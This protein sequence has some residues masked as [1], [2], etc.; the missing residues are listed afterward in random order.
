M[1]E[2]VNKILRKD[3]KPCPFCGNPP[4]L[5]IIPKEENP[6]WYKGGEFWRIECSNEWCIPRPSIRFGDL[7]VICYW[8]ER[9][10]RNRLTYADDYKKSIYEDKEMFNETSNTI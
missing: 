4:Y 9:R 2:K 6:E 10:R 3:L 5:Y 7:S 1:K 8:Q